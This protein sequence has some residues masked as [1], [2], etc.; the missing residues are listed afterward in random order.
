M[1]RFIEIYPRTPDD[2]YYVPG[3]ME[4]DDIVE[5][6]IGMIKQIMLT[7][8]GEVL[9]DPTFGINLESLLF[10]FDVSQTEL[11]QAIGLQLYTYCPPSREQ[12]NISYKVGFFN[13]TTRDTCVIEFAIS[14]NP[15]LGIRII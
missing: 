6:A 12:L 4:T 10:D 8:P 7:S 2:P 9:G 13:G 14:G 3:I 1:A 15:V 5:I 11:Q